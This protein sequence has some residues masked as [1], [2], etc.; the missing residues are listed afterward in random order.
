MKG[1]WESE[2]VS[3]WEDDR[4]PTP[5]PLSHFIT[6]SPAHLPSPGTELPTRAHE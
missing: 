3:R 5:F 6:F 2:K 1:K 4:R